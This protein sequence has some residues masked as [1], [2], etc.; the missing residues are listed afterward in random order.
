[1]W[2]YDS[3][4]II[5]AYTAEEICTRA[6]SGA[7]AKK[8]AWDCVCVCVCVCVIRQS[9]LIA[10]VM[11]P[12]CHQPQIAQPPLGALGLVSSIIL[13]LLFTLSKANKNTKEK[14]THCVH[15]LLG[16]SLNRKQMTH[17]RTDRVL[18]RVRESL[19]GRA[20][21]LRAV[22]VATSFTRIKCMLIS[23]GNNGVR[24]GGKFSPVHTESET[25]SGTNSLKSAICDEWSVCAKYRIS[26]RE[27]AA[28]A[29][30]SQPTQQTQQRQQP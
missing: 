6:H 18:P 25:D 27:S 19:S 15:V 13:Q 9:I 28:A 1:M 14:C 22:A 21:A 3:R 2:Q 29:T 4:V 23:N 10:N 5:A 7:V 17:S 11:L 12:V 8:S 24:P 20:A 26:N 30:A 16:S